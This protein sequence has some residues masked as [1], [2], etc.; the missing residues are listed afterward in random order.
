[1]QE[2]YH[3]GPTP[4]RGHESPAPARHD[5]RLAVVIFFCTLGE[6]LLEH[7][8]REAMM[9]LDLPSAVQ[10]RLLADNL[11]AKQRLEK[12]FPT[13]TGTK[14]KAA[15]AQLAPAQQPLYSNTVEFYLDAVEARNR[16]LHDGN[17][18]AIPEEMPEKCIRAISPLV[19]LFVALHNSIVRAIYRREGKPYYMTAP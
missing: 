14:W 11:Y 16:F 2:I 10:D 9:A 15:M 4:R 13:V 7:F 1:M 3:S 19:S 8:L 5:H 18:W 12:V 17:K 6:V